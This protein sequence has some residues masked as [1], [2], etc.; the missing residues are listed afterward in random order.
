MKTSAGFE[1]CYNGQTAVDG[2]AQ[3][4]VAAELTNCAADHGELPRMLDVVTA[5]CGDA[6]AVALADVGYR[7]EA[8]LAQLSDSAT[9][10]LVALGREG[11]GQVAIDADQRPHT[12]AMAAKL[13]TAEG[14]AGAVS[15]PQSDRRTAQRLAQAGA[16]LP[17]VQPAGHRQGALRVQAGV[18]R[19]EPA[20]HGGDDGLRREAVRHPPW[21]RP[22]NPCPRPLTV[23][24]APLHGQPTSS[25]HGAIGRWRQRRSSTAQTPRSG[26]HRPPGTFFRCT[27]R[28]LDF[29]LLVILP[30][31]N[32]AETPTAF[33]QPLHA[34]RLMILGAGPF[35]L[36]IIQRAVALGCEVITVDYLPDNVGHKLSQ[37]YVNCST[38]DRDGVLAGAQD[39]KID[40]ICTYSSDVA[41]PTVAYVASR[42]GLPAVSV[43]AG[44]TMATK[45]RFRAF[46][47]RAGLPHPRFV[48]G[49]NFDSVAATLTR[50]RFP[51]VFK[52][53]DTSG[54]RGVIRLGT[55][56]EQS[57]RHAFDRAR[58]FSRSG[59]VCVEEFIEGIEVGGD[60]ILI[61]G[62]IAFIAITHKHLEGF[63]VRGHSLPTNVSASAQQAVTDA[64][65]ETCCALGYRT[66]PLNFDAIVSPNDEVTLLEI[67]PRNGG[68]GIGAVIERATGVDVAEATIRIALG[69]TPAFPN[70][71]E[72]RRGC[73]S[74]VFGSDRG[75]HLLQIASAEELRRRVPQV[76]DVMYAVPIGSP[77]DRFEHN[78]NLLGVALFDCA[79]AGHYE[80]TVHAIEQNLAIVIEAA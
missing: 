11:K 78:G 10:V 52:P 75:G 4:I 36:P 28:A 1:Q 29:T 30:V 20:A 49:T 48:A 21:A 62:E 72:V 22:S 34:K 55:N 32:Q 45:H 23:P 58:S 70:R 39:L 7:S 31:R 51:V 43:E 57:A 17:A 3:I 5:T 77:V 18:C 37:R 79:D 9:A 14:R 74:Y 16:G 44:E 26:G 33:A 15:P 19:A 24:S 71:G 67:S 64:L 50:L 47:R 38:V 63:V 80:Q 61:D 2:H 6:P 59:T 56:D 73:G 25:G 54:S 68:N 69:E 12:A 76:F 35:Q 66:G 13:Q 40:G 42:L 60:A 65:E 46:L 27:F 41:I 8:T 53:V